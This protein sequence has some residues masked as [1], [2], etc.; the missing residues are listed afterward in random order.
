VNRIVTEFVDVR[1][2]PIEKRAQFAAYLRATHNMSQVEIG[3]LLGGLSQPHVSRLLAYAEKAGYLVVEHRFCSE[4]LGESERQDLAGLLAPSALTKALRE[5]CRRHGQPVPGL[6][7]FESGPGSTRGAMAQRRKR[8]GKTAAGR[9]IE[10]L[11]GQRIAG[12]AWGRTIHAVIEGIAAS[13]LPLSAID[14]IE[15]V[16]VCAELL[17]TSQRELSSS[18]LA[19]EL[20]RV[21]RAEGE[22]VLQLTGFPAY[23]P[24]HYEEVMQRAAWRLIRDAPN[25]ERI[26]SGPDAMVT[27]MDVLM[28]SVGFSET[29]VLGGLDDLLRAGRIDPQDLRALVVGDLGGLLIPRPDLTD[30]QNALIDELNMMWTGISLDQVAGIAARA[31]ASSDMSGVI[32][33]ALRAERSKTLLELVRLGLVNQL[34]I[35]HDAAAGLEQ[36]LAE[37]AG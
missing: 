30:A 14:E 36:C 11:G 4:N 28:T 25:Y 6:G 8:F 32:V 24:R 7:V 21:L 29:L 33:L 10:L 22:D 26:F 20:T 3:R 27:R 16:P 1:G 35:D 15:L 18:R 17:L 23:V 9:V 5:F 13:H 12:I 34:V 31:R 19:E 37:E 2:L